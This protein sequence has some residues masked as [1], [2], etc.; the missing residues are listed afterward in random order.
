MKNY[1]LDFKFVLILLLTLSSCLPSQG[2]IIDTIDSEQSTHPTP[3]KAAL[4][5]ITIPTQGLPSTSPPA[6]ELPLLPKPNSEICLYQSYK[7]IDREEIQESEYVADL[8]R[9]LGFQV[10]E[11]SDAC[12]QLLVIDA[13]GE[14]LGATF[15]HTYDEGSSFCYMGAES[16][17]TFVFYVG[18]EEIERFEANQSYPPPHGTIDYCRA[19]DEAPLHRVW[20][21]PLFEGIHHFFGIEALVQGLRLALNNEH[22][23]TQYGAYAVL[24][25][26]DV[27]A[28]PVL[29]KYQFDENYIVQTYVSRTIERLQMKSNTE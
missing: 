28:L 4:T 9:A 14:P 23:K 24:Q 13:R 10:K 26:V 22:Y 3:L 21:Q 29:M 15:Q 25:Q 20:Y 27:D 18:E 2:S 1:V 5:E 12:Q 7:P 17:F 11:P 6:P 19:E 8:I 16:F